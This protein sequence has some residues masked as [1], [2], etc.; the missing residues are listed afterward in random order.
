MRW[1]IVCVG[2]LTACTATPETGDGLVD[3]VVAREVGLATSACVAVGGPTAIVKL[4]AED[5]PP[6][7]LT[8]QAVKN[9]QAR[10]AAQAI[11]KSWHDVQAEKPQIYG[12]ARSGNCAMHVNGPAYSEDFAFVSYA[13]PGGE[14]GAYVFR[15]TDSRWQIIE[16]VKLGYW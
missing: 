11:A 9:A 3:A 8:A 4:G 14:M 6:A 7:M 1:I 12:D 13:S 5:G 2:F 16:R 15:K 10:R